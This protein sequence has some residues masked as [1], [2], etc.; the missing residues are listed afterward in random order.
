M[1]LISQ[2]QNTNLG[3]TEWYAARR[4]EKI[5]DMRS[6]TVS[7]KHFLQSNFCKLFG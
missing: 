2:L 5:Y 7:R 6:R 4:K 1:A 3:L